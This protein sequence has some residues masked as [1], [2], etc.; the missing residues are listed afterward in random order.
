MTKVQL[1]LVA[2]GL[3]V[4]GGLALFAW[5]YFRKGGETHFKDDIWKQKAAEEKRQ[6]QRLAYEDQVDKK[7]LIDHKPDPKDPDELKAKSEPIPFKAP[8]FRGK[9][10]EILGIPSDANAETISKAHKFWIKRYHPDRVT[11]LGPNYIEQAR[12]RAE[13]LNTA[14][15]AMLKK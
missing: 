6:N 14:R 2:D 5:M 12:K 10:H 11:H 8:N 9:P 4:V 7:I 15:Q 13:Q 1:F 3:I